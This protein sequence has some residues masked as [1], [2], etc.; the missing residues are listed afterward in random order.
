MDQELDPRRSI[1]NHALSGYPYPEPEDTYNWRADASCKGMPPEI[2]FPSR[3]DFAMEVLAREVCSG[4]VVINECLDYA[5][6]NHPVQGFWGNTSMR[7]RRAMRKRLRV[8]D[9]KA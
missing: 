9:G 3:G 4:C 6:Q 5:I 8:I 1:M 7:Q 2:F